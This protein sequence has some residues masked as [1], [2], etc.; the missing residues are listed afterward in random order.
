MPGLFQWLGLLAAVARQL[1]G[2]Q[3]EHQGEPAHPPS[4]HADRAPDVPVHARKHDPRG[5]L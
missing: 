3:T 5:L 4:L 1:R 2:G